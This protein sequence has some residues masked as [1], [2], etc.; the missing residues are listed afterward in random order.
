MNDTLSN[1]I[2]VRCFLHALQ[3]SSVVRV[4]DASRV[5]DDGEYEVGVTEV[6]LD[7][8]GKV[9]IDLAI[10]TGEAKGSVVRLRNNMEQEPI[11]WL[12]LPGHLRVEDGVPLFRLDQ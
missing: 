4:R 1:A 2:N 7:D 9:V 3:A 10:A 12:G 5:I 6:A 8:D 11:D